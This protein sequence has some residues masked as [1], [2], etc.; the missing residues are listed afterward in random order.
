[1]QKSTEAKRKKTFKT[2]MVSKVKC[3]T[4]C[5]KDANI[6]LKKIIKEN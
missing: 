4:E 3:C 2:G 1:M 6:S 5:P